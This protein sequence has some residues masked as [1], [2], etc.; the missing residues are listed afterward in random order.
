VNS[1]VE[2]ALIPGSSPGQALTLS[3]FV[4]EGKND[5]GGRGSKIAAAVAVEVE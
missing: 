3:H 1:F 4:G 2:S 5:E